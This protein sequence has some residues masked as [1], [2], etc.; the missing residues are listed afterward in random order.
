MCSEMKQALMNLLLYAPVAFAVAEVLLAFNLY[1]PGM[2]FIR[3][4]LTELDEGLERR[5][6]LG[7]A[8]VGLLAHLV[9]LL[10]SEPYVR[11]AAKAF[12]AVYLFILW[13]V[14]PRTLLV[15]NGA[16]QIVR[17]DQVERNQYVILFFACLNAM[18]IIL[19]GLLRPASATRD[20]VLNQLRAPGEPGAPQPNP[21]TPQPVDLVAVLLT[22]MMALV[23]Y[24]AMVQD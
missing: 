8:A 1:G 7:D 16:E 17:I 24:N 12:Y 11:A 6:L 18:P 13:W 20:P 4:Q 3:G 23:V 19:P 5:G 2:P 14:G 21:D 15:M 10:S 9:V 22:A